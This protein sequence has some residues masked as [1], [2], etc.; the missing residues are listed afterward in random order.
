LHEDLDLGRLYPANEYALSKWTNEQQISNFQ[1]RYGLE[2]TRL[3]FFNAYGPGEEPHPYRSV[4]AL[5]CRRALRGEP[6]PVYEGYRRAFMYIEDFIPTLANVCETDCRHDVYNIGG[7]DY[8]SVMELAQIVLDVTRSESIIEP[9]PEDLHNVRSKRPDISRARE[10]FDHDP[11]TT[12]EDG[13]PETIAWLQH[14]M[15]V[16]GLI[17][18]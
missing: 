17:E 2:S 1:R 4:V 10:E 9:I 12:L 5:F 3:R 14:A 8:R 13:I 7:S 18:T 15:A 11:Q 6:L 16:L